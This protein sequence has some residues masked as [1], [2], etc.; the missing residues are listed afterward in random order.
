MKGKASAVLFPES[1][2]E[3]KK[4]LQPDS[5]YYKYFSSIEADISANKN[6]PEFLKDEVKLNQPEI[7]KQEKSDPLRTALKMECLTL[8]RTALN[9]QEAQ[10][11]D[12]QWEIIESLIENKAHLLVVQRT[13]W[14]KS[15]IYFIATQILRKRG[16]GPSIII[17]PLIAL[18]R[19]QIQGAERIGL[20]SRTIHSGN[21]AEW[22]IIYEELEQGLID[23]L[24]VSPERLSN[25]EFREKHLLPVAQTIGLFVID[26]AH[27]ISEWGHDFRPDYQ[28]ILKI[29]QFLP[30]KLSSRAGY[31][32][33]FMG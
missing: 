30:K 15:F 26:E 14:G 25:D 9:S 3:I 31:G 32:N 8:L 20:H 18:M 24:I 22:D 4:I 5:K 23:L 16:S 2:Q 11:R 21:N 13:G 28:R 17:S 27:C 7:Q 6:T 29:L 12:N 1:I 19:N 33:V 10:F